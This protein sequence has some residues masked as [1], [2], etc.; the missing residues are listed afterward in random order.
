MSEIPVVERR[1]EAHR[2]VSSCLRQFQSA[3]RPELGN[4]G[5]TAEIFEEIFGALDGYGVA[6]SEWSLPP[7]ET[8]LAGEARVF[9]LFN[10]EHP[11]EV[12]FESELWSA[13]KVREPVIRGVLTSENGNLMFAFTAIET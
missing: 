8:A 10:M 7:L 5:I 11:H 6:I 12:G 9:E 13:G 1:A 3:Y 4:F 2:L